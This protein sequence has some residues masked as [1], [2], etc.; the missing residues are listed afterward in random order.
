MEMNKLSLYVHVPFCVSKCRYCGFY[1]TRYDAELAERYIEGIRKELRLSSDILKREI[2]SIYMG[3]GTPSMLSA[4]QLKTLCV[5]LAEGTDRT[6]DCEWTMEA[7]P[8]SL[9]AEKLDVLLAAG[10]NRLSIGIQSFSDALLKFLGRPHSAEEGRS[11]VVSARNAGFRNIGIDLIFGIP[12]QTEQEWS[13]TLDQAVHLSPDHVSAYS[14]SIDEGSQFCHLAV[15]GGMALPDEEQ[16]ADRYCQ[17]VGKLEA[18][19]YAQYEISNFSKPGFACRHN[20]AYWER[21]E[22]LGIGPSA[23]SFLGNERWWNIADVRQYAALLEAGTSAVGGRE[24]VD[25]AQSLTET[26]MLGLRLSAGI[27]LEMIEDRFGA[28]VR[29]NV[30]ARV[31]ELEHAGL[32]CREAGML[33]LT[34]RGMLLS[35]EALARLVA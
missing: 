24:M 26:L 30:T 11:A 1:S 35:N 28:P 20:L 14:L 19:G 31:E 6:P 18:A 17:T 27:A 33:R 13:N 29:R 3:G 7:N 32:F 22:Y 5:D 8:G 2:C 21:N 16:V 9:T 23:W 4:G 15:S 10:V 12:G 25:E 34:R